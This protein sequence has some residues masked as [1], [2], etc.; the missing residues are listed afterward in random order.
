M[1]FSQLLDFSE[2]GERDR[3]RVSSILKASN[4]LLAIVNE[5]LDIS[6]VEEGSLSISTE[7]VAV[8]PLVD[9]AIE[10]MRPLA[11]AMEVVIRSPEFSG[12]NGYVFGD[13]QRPKQV[14]INLIA[15]AIKYNRRGG[16]V[17]VAVEG[18]GS[19]RVRISVVDSGKGI[20]EES[21]QRLFVPFERL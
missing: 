11:Q 4:H 21:L 17:R 7:A 15:N 3:Q 13:N 16:E 19:E 6:R 1:G 20:D 2:L 5:V 18:A 10:L 8:Q 9:E 12:G 14:V